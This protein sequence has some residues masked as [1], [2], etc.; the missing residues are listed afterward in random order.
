MPP[1]PDADLALVTATE[2][3][4]G[5][6]EARLLLSRAAAVGPDQT[7]VEIGN[8]RGRSTVALALGSRAGAGV[9]VTTFD[10]HT[11]FVGPRGGRFGHADQEA[12]Y[13]NLI[14]AGV[15]A[16]VSVVT[17][18]ARLVGP[19]W[20]ARNVGLLF[21]DG[22]HRYEAVRADFL[23]WAPHLVPGA[24]VIFDDVDFGDVAR[25]LAEFVADGRLIRRE[26][27]GKVGRFEAP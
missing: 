27:V 17:L 16:L 3:W 8:Y 19:V 21:I 1:I 14:R 23:T 5:A 12:L 20:P 25:C 7:I 11:P 6:D 9:Q 24:T 4:L 18:D 22:D 10:P 26:T 13:A 2:G 15:G